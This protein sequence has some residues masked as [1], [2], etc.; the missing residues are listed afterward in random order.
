MP[1][2]SRAP[3]CWSWSTSMGRISPACFNGPNAADLRRLRNCTSG[4]SGIA[5]HPRAS[6]VHRDIKPSNLILS[7]PPS[8]VRGR[9]SGGEGTQ[10]EG[11]VKIL[12]LGLALLVTD[13][14]KHGE[15]TSAELGPG[16]GRLH[17]PGAGFGRPLGGYSGRHLFARLH[18]L[19]VA[20]R[21]ASVQRAAVP[22]PRR[23]DGR[24]L[25]GDAAAAAPAS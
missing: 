23:E 18:A 11:L 14:P 13:Q 6:H 16:H 8:P 15:F 21:P 10:G 3:P 25:E 2:T 12:D 24:S 4:G 20:R 7:V 5:I 19:R 22:D 1:E 17:S 9:G